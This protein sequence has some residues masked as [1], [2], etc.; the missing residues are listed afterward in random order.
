MAGGRVQAGTGSL[1]YEW[2]GIAGP[3]VARGLHPI[4]GVY[5]NTSLATLHAANLTTP[6]QDTEGRVQVSERGCRTIEVMTPSN[7]MKNG[8]QESGRSSA[9]NFS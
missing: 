6:T 9:R 1:V 3:R 8:Q 5:G 7:V 4:T 2:E